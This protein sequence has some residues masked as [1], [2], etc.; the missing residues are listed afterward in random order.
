MDFDLRAQN[1][2]GLLTQEKEHK[3]RK[4]NLVGTVGQVV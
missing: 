4:Q 1:V 3:M 2:G